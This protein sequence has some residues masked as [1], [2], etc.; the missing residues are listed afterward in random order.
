MSVY[1]LQNAGVGLQTQLTGQLIEPGSSS[2]ASRKFSCQI[3]TSV[4]KFSFRKR[5]VRNMAAS[6]PEAE[7]KFWKTPELVEGL[8]PHLDPPST[9]ELAKVH[10]LTSGILQGISDWNRFIRRSCPFPPPNSPTSSLTL[11]EQMVTKLRPIIGIMELIG[12]PQSHLLALLDVICERFTPRNNDIDQSGGPEY[13]IKVTCPCHEFHHVSALGFVLLE[14]VEAA[15]GSS[16]QQLGSVFVYSIEGSLTSALKS[17]ML[18][19]EWMV[20]QVEAHFYSCDTQD[21][22]E[23]LPTLVQHTEEF[24]F[25]RLVIGG[26]IAEGGW[27]ALA[28]ALRLLP[29]LVLDEGGPNDPRGFQALVVRSKHLMVGGR[30]EDVRSVWDAL[31]HG[32]HLMLV[33]PILV[34]NKYFPSDSWV[35]LMEAWIATLIVLVNC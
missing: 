35:G 23:A 27:A 19:Q 16:E 25:R 3:E 28:E 7:E 24:G 29:P 33:N 21:E 1:S 26:A 20:S 11:T 14:F 5:S 10:P 9:L 15:L 17:R 18:R 4:V 30:R 32:S 12:G 22:A 2:S 31:P 34:W 6:G 8:L 13:Y